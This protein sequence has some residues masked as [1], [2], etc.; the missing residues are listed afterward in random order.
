MVGASG[1][2]VTIELAIGLGNEDRL[3]RLPNV[4]GIFSMSQ[5]I[6]PNNFR[7]FLV[8]VSD[9]KVSRTVC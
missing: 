5:N 2:G 9:Y 1:T 3:L 8:D 7:Y 4:G 6:F